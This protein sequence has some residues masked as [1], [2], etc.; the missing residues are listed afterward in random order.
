MTSEAQTQPLTLVTL[1]VRD[2]RRAVA[3]YTDVGFERV[4]DDDDIAFFR[5]GGS[6]L[7]LYDWD[8]LAA[9]AQVDATGTG[10]RGVSLASNQPSE[11]AVDDEVERWAAAGATL[12]KPPERV[13]WGGYS[14]Y[15]ADPDGH[16]WELAHNPGPLLSPGGGLVP[17]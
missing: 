11:Q 8:D 10:F 9:D 14:G 3:F 16:L 5:T 15:V 12:V 4:G 2:L 1:G 7:A 17:A 13:F 6:V